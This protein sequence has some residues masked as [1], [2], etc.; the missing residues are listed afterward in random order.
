MIL[1]TVEKTFLHTS[2]KAISLFTAL[3]LCL[4]AMP[5][6]YAASSVAGRTE[7]S[8][9]LIYAYS[10]YDISLRNASYYSGAEDDGK[11]LTYTKYSSVTVDDGGNDHT[12]HSND[13]I[14]C[15][16]GVAQGQ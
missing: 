8:R 3:L 9:S 13:G 6:V 14:L 2:K 16:H 4:S 7:E 12:A 11:R 15:C 5:S 1:K 10:E